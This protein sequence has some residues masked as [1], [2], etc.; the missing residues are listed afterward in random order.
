MAQL[1]GHIVSCHVRQ[2]GLVF[3]LGQ[4]QHIGGHVGKTQG[5]LLDDGQIFLPV[6]L[7]QISPAQEFCE[8]GNGHDGRLE[9]MGKIVDEVGT[10]HLRILKLLGHFIKAFSQCR[11]TGVAPDQGSCLDAGVKIAAGQAIHALHQL[12]HRAK[13]QFTG[14]DGND[15]AK[16]QTDAQHDG[17]G[18]PDN[19]DHFLGGGNDIASHHEEGHHR[20]SRHRHRQGAENNDGKQKSQTKEGLGQSDLHTFFT[21]LYPRP[22]TLTISNSSQPSN[23]RRRRPTWTVTVSQPVSLS[24]PQISSISWI[25]VKIFPGSD[26]SL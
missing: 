8:P 6:C 3:K 24:A 20:S 11:Q 21:A 19:G 7:R 22:R 26:R 16:Q 14:H 2:D 18:G 25:R 13:G 15:G 17:A 4:I 12:P 1:L 23:R 5:L 9:L 10:E